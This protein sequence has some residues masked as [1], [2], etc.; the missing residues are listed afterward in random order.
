V[1]PHANYLFK[2]ALV[3]DAAY[4]TLLREPRRALHARIAEILESQFVEIAESQPEL[5]ARH[6]TEAGLI[7]KAAGL[8]GKAGLRS[9]ERSALVEAVAQLRRALDQF[10]ILRPTPAFRREEIKLQVALITPL[11]H[12]KGF[13]APETKAAADR[14]RLLIEQAA[15]LGEPPEDP[16]LLFSVLYAFWV[17]NQVAFNGDVLRELARQF[18]ALAEEKGATA[19]LMIGHR[20]M[21]NSLLETGDTAEARAHYDRALA[22]Y[23]PGEHRVLAT[24]FFGQ[25]ARVATLS[26]R[27]SALWLLGYPEGALADA[28]QALSDAREIGQAA[29]LMFALRHTSLTRIHCGK[30]ATANAQLEELLALAEEKGAALWKAAGTIQ[31]GFVLALTGKVAEAV[32]MI[33]SGIIAWRSTGATIYLPLYLSHLARA[34]AQLGQLDDAWRCIGEAMTA[35]ETTKERWYEAEANRVA[36][37]IAQLS[38]KSDAAKVEANFERALAV[39]RQQQAKSWELR[40]AMGLTRLWRDQGKVQQAREL[41]APVY[42]WFTEGFDTRDLKEAKALLDELHA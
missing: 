5:L 38:P 13:A 27:S 14:A 10:A 22:L 23:D 25:D 17:A 32:R 12:V 40:A 33:P 19:P 30:Y 16:L 6:C 26:Y 28:D 34:Y 8:W 3:Q 21:A 29:T 15:A 41:L 9:L 20:L 37:E 1:P 31:Q 11:F 42:G 24:R 4:G 39:A 2:H 36:G 35:V 7:E 18:L